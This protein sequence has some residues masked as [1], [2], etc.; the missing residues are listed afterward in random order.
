MVTIRRCPR[1]KVHD[2]R[3]VWQLRAL[4]HRE[5]DQEMM[6]HA[7]AW[8]EGAILPVD[9]LRRAAALGF[10][11]MKVREELG[12]AALGH[13]DATIIFEELT[14]GC[15]STAAY[16]SIHNIRYVINGTKAF[17]EVKAVL[18]RRAVDLRNQP[19][20]LRECRSVK[21]GPVTYRNKLLGC[22]SGMFA[23]PATNVNAEFSV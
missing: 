9:M 12:G 11:G 2:Q 14:Q 16:I 1:G 10:G 15:T 20:R 17:I 5:L 8:D 23:A 22:L 19:A 13:L 7:A 6:P 4:L 3:H 21:S 18:H